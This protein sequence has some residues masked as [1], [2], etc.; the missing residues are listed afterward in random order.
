MTN[1]RA[2][3]LLEYLGTIT[4]RLSGDQVNH[5][6]SIYTQEI[7]TERYRNHKAPICTCDG[8]AWKL[9]IDET[10]VFAQNVVDAW[11]KKKAK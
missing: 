7:N 1:K 9:M 11:E 8:K 5:L 4:H 2:T 6:W 10:R 3:E